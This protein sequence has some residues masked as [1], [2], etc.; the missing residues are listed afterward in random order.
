MA[1]ANTS[2]K[3]SKA[4][5]DEEVISKSAAQDPEVEE[6][7]DATEETPEVV[8]EENPTAD[9]K[10]DDSNKDNSDEDSFEILDP[11]ANE[12]V[13]V[14]GKP[15]ED[16]GTEDQYSRYVQRPLGYI[17]RA[18][19]FALVSRTVAE[20]IKAGGSVRF[21]GTDLLAGEGTIRQRAYAMTESDF[22]DVASFVALAMQLVG[23]VDDFLLDCFCL[24]LDVPKSE[25]TWAKR[26]M[27]MPHDPANNL[28][29]LSD[30][31]AEEIIAHF[32]DQNYK[33]IRDFFAERLPRLAKRAQSQERRIS[34]SK[35]SLDRG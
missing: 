20:A 29:G 21:N 17:Q 18:R 3:K 13:W 30:D 19:F 28:Y 14:I 7:N 12:K 1:T 5:V 22:G 6:T 4:D 16:G 35:K 26:I 27:A 34:S 9:E 33:D 32:I 31:Q 11:L 25:I 24:W 15:P 10:S 2:K 23:Y 8:E